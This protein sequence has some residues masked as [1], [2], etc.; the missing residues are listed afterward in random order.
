MVCNLSY[1]RKYFY[2]NRYQCDSKLQIL[3]ATS[4]CASD[5]LYKQKIPSFVKYLIHNYMKQKQ[6]TNFLSDYLKS[7]RKG[8]W[9]AELMISPGWMAKD[10]PPKNRKMYDRKREKRDWKNDHSNPAFKIYKITNLFS[11]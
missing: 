1:T 9:E 4:L 6:K 3:G 8:S 7:N 5:I 11:S 10:K 2:R